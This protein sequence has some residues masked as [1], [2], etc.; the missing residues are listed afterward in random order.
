MARFRFFFMTERS[1][2][3]NQ[4]FVAAPESIEWSYFV[5]LCLPF[6]PIY[7]CSLP[8][9]F[10]VHSLKEQLKFS[11]H[12]NESSQVDAFHGRGAKARSTCQG[13]AGHRNIWTNEENKWIAH[14]RSTRCIK[15]LVNFG[16]LD[17]SLGIPTY[18]IISPGAF[19]ILPCSTSLLAESVFF[20]HQ[21][22]L[23]KT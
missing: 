19:W 18:L 6:T 23:E 10:L 13:M 17:R 5:I 8:L 7:F 21:Q 9:Y 11:F 1:K 12:R 2:H 3:Q 15:M 16:V 14:I 4:C 22:H 20:G